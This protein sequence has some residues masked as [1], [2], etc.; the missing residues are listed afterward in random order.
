MLPYKEGGSVYRVRSH[1]SKKLSY[2]EAAIKGRGG[3]V[4]WQHAPYKEAACILRAVPALTTVGMGS[5]QETQGSGGYTLI[6][7]LVLMVISSLGVD[8]NVE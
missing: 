8:L 5:C 3:S 1:L 2:K 6:L 4:W 7:V